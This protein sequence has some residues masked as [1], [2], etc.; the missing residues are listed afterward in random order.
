MGDTKILVWDHNKDEIVPCADTILSDPEAARFVWGIAFHWYSGDDFEQLAEV[1]THV[2]RTSTWCSPKA[3]RRGACDSAS[4]DLGER[5]GHAIIG[6]L[7]H[8]AAGW[9]DWNMVLNREGGPNHVGNFCDAPII[10]DTEAGKV[11]YQSSYYYL[12][13][14]SRYFL[15]GSVMVETAFDAAPGLEGTACR[16]PDGSMAVVVMNTDGAHRRF[17]VRD[18]DRCATTELPGHSIATLLYD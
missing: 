15:P 4:W 10:A 7:N 6:D 11:H 17:Q 14:F 8:G 3:A 9:I 16:R 2:S 12:A 13:H 1:H 18:G 5:Y